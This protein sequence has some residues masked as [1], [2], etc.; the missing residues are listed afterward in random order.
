MAIIFK[1]TNAG[2]A[3]LVNAQNNGTLARTVVSVGVTATAF[4]P[5]PTLAAI[6]NE[7]K[8][9]ATLA[10]DVV[11]PD[12][13]HVTVRD[14][15]A[16]TYT[17]RGLGLWLDNGVLLG[18]YSQAAVIVEK[19]PAG[20]MLLA[21]DLRVLDGSVDISTLVFGNKDFLNPPATTERQGVVELAT[22]AEA[23]A[24]A[25]ATRALTPA[26]V[27]APFAARALVS[28]TI[29]A[30]TGLTG[31]GTLGASRT[32]AL[33]NT[34]VAAGS[35]GS[36]TAVPTFTVDAQGRLVAAGTVAVAPPW[37][38]ITGKPT[39]LAGYGITDAALSARRILAGTGLAGGGDFTA[40]R[41]VSLA[42][43][44]VAPGSYG[45][46]TTVPTFT[47][48]AQGRLTAAGSAAIPAATQAAAG[49]MSAADK[50]TV[51]GLPAALSQFPTK[52]GA[53]ATGT[54][55]INING[56]S[57]GVVA[58]DSR[59]VNDAPG[60]L[61]ARSFT[62]AFKQAG[63]VGNPPVLSTQSLYAHVLN[64]C[65]WDA[66][67]G[68]GGWPSQ[69]SVGP[70][71]LAVRSGINAEAWGAWL[72]LAAEGTSPTFAAVTAATFTGALKG[73]A[74]TATNAAS[75]AKIGGID[76]KNGD[77]TTPSTNADAQ[78]VNGM[79]YVKDT[80]AILGQIDGGLYSQAYGPT[81]VHQMYG[82]YRT[83]QMAVRGRNSGAWQ[84]WRTVLDSGNFNTWAPTKTGGGASGSW[85]INAA[86]ATKLETP[87]RINRTPFDGSADIAVQWASEAIPA[88]ADLNNYRTEGVYHCAATATAATLANC[89]AQ[90]AFGLRVMQA[91]GFIQEVIE[92]PVAGAKMWRRHFYSG[93][94][95][96]WYR[97][98][99]EAD[100]QPNVAGN[101]G[102]ATRLAVARNLSLTGA[103]TGTATAFDGSAA[104]AIP[105]T[106]I[107]LEHSG[108]AGLLG[109]DH[110]GVAPGTFIH[111]AGPNP[112]A[113]Y[114]RANGA[115]V[116]RATYAAL[117]AALGTHYGGGDGA[118]TFN[119]PDTRG[120]FLRGLDE[121]RGVDPQ[122]VLGTVQGSQNLEHQHSGATEGAGHHAHGGTTNWDGAHQ[123]NTQKDTGNGGNAGDGMV[124]AWGWEGYF[125]TNAGDGAHAHGFVTDGAGNHNHAFNTSWSGGSES[126]PINLATHIFIKF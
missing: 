111:F 116:S 33:A 85:A 8:R 14:D 67:G 80:N 44:A 61:P 97:V 6:P 25:D 96:V 78:T 73:N 99:S 38:S 16:D 118:T 56:L 54:W 106:G 18:T 24:M 113:G 95:G 35:Y 91:S 98:Y 100:P 41:T 7:I 76:F 13:V 121:G 108:M 72:K 3:A 23:A 45:N 51:D 55:P 79:S 43:T 26:S 74:D 93:G 110:G 119:L 94:W 89:P 101:A 64:L 59:A 81:W 66:Q 29:T 122:R 104:I 5:G 30:G 57:L 21:L 112:P 10:G 109:S 1:L 87:R 124:T 77:A 15:G 70:A 117:F 27:A 36:A 88:N 40:D 86:T 4:N 120:L 92:Y 114:L 84:P 83:G 107:N 9:I 123:H 42:N 37:G 32:I 50:T 47:V 52:A 12:T 11:A 126:R 65:G 71:G 125:P 49:L 82:D 20:I 19:S 28:T 68:S 75:A 53:G 48:D 46:A 22:A 58:V 102:T 90:M 63:A 105:V 2:R 34:A 60:Q 115:Q 69:I 17:V 62:V 39:T 31:G 103:A